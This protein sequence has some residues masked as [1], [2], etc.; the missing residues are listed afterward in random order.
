M[1]LITLGSERVNLPFKAHSHQRN[2]SHG[3][4]KIDALKGPFTRAPYPLLIGHKG[5]T[6]YLKTPFFPISADLAVF[7]CRLPVRGKLVSG[8]VQQ[9][10]IT[11]A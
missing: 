1:K 9:N 4:D 2:K 8:F 6:Y 5:I 11:I 10:R 7:C 3:S